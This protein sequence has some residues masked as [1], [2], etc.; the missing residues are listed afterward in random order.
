MLGCPLRLCWASTTKWQ[1]WT[2]FRRRLIWLI[3]KISDSRWLY[4]KISCWKRTEFNSN[5]RCRSCLY[6]CR[7]CSHCSSNKCLLNKPYW[8]SN[9]EKNL[10]CT[11]YRVLKLVIF[12]SRMNWKHQKFI[13]NAELLAPCGTKLAQFFQ[14]LWGNGEK[15]VKITKVHELI[16]NVWNC[17]WVHYL[18]R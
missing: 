4:W 10:F 18:T 13:Q 17:C 2:L 8:R 6:R 1:Q 11:L 15:Q 16:I 14:M 7:F 5:I 9:V 12:H 3:K